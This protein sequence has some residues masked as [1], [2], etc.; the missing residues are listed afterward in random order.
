MVESFEEPRFPLI[1]FGD[2]MIAELRRKKLI[3]DGTGIKTW[4]FLINPTRELIARYDLKYGEELDPTTGFAISQYP[5]VEAE[6]LSDDPITGKVMVLTDFKGQPTKFSL[7]YAEM[8]EQLKNEQ[9][10][11]K[12]LKSENAYLHQEYLKLA[13]R[14]RQ[15]IKADT[16]TILEARKAGGRVSPEDEF[17]PG[18]PGP[19]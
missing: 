7:R 10:L 11:N 1:V 8:S 18:I 19:V 4:V 9:K 6:I 14:T 13:A 2:G 17:T 3:L 5:F 16:E 12:S 15:K